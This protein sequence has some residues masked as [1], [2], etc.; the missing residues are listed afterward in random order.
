MWVRLPTVK[1][2]QPCR[3]FVFR[4]FVSERVRVTGL[5]R[6]SSGQLVFRLVLTRNLQIATSAEG[7]KYLF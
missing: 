2:N 4:D 7:G 3:S 1:G 6:G 5:E